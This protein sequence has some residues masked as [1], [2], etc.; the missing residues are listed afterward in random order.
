MTCKAPK[1]LLSLVTACAL[2]GAIPVARADNVAASSQP[3]V[4][5]PAAQNLPEFAGT[6]PDEARQ[7]FRS[8]LLV[9][10][11]AAGVLW[12]GAVHWWKDD[13]NSH[14]SSV[15]EGWFSQ[16][17]YAGGADKL[18]HMYTNYV[19][20]R[21]LTRAFEWAGHDTE[22]AAWL[23]AATTWGAMLAVEVGDGFSSRYRFS[24]EDLI[25]NTVGTGLGLWMERNPELDEI[26]DFRMMYKPS[27]DAR[28]LNQVDPVDDHSGQT[29][30]LIAKAAGI[31][32]LRGIEPLRYFELALGYG[33]RGYEPN[34]G[35]EHSRNIYYGISLNV[36]ELLNASVFRDS[37]GSRAHKVTNGILEVFQIP[38]TAA[39]ANHRL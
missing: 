24:K 37:R 19:G 7:R 34:A 10:G 31:P 33:S 5:Q 38:G 16:D 2:A 9:G 22:R 36:A 6:G 13:M 11:A 20:T 12:Y 21:L 39:L 28:R 32:A 3:I 14:F 18:G 15:N 1:L 27:D 23:A 8:R 35:G 29:Y 30:L 4:F 26:L 25:M 17:T